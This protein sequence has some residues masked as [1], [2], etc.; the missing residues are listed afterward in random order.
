MSTKELAT[1]LAALRCWQR[2]LAA[3]E[4]Q[5]ERPISQEYFQDVEPLTVSEIDQLCERLNCG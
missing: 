2:T 5:G 3:N 1:V 4:A